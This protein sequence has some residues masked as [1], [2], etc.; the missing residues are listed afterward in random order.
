MLTVAELP[1][2]DTRDGQQGWVSGTNRRS[3]M[4]LCPGFSGNN[5]KKT[6]GSPQKDQVLGNRA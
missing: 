4:E 2:E 3:R 6:P 1:V 5:R